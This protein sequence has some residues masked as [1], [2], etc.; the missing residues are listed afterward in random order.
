SALFAVDL[1]SP[2]GRTRTPLR[3]RYSD[4]AS[5]F[6]PAHTLAALPL[7]GVPFAAGH[8]HALVITNDVRDARGNPVGRDGALSRALGLAA[9]TSADIDA[10]KALAPFVDW[11]RTARF[12]LRRVALATV[13]TVQDAA[14]PIVGLRR[15]VLAA[16]APS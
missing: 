13:F 1:D 3:L 10:R 5:L 15:G 4:A 11:T 16:P 12:D 14:A 6:L 8:R 2:A 9:Q 7:Y